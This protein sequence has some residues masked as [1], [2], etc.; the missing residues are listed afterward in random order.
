LKP[1]KFGKEAAQVFGL[2]RAT[3]AKRQG[4]S[5]DQKI[6]AKPTLPK[7]QVPAGRSICSSRDTKYTKKHKRFLVYHFV[8][9]QSIRS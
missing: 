6:A 5:E 7:F 9:M 4:A 1:G 3:I 8:R 2:E